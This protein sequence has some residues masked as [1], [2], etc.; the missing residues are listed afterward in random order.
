MSLFLKRQQEV[1]EARAS[2]ESSP[3]AR[4]LGTMPAKRQEN[5]GP[6]PTGGPMALRQL[7]AFLNSAL[8]V[9]LAA[10]SS[11]SGKT[12][13]KRVIKRD[14]LLPKYHEYVAQLTEGGRKHELVGRYLVW[15]IDALE[16]DQ[17]L[18]LAEWCIENGQTLPQNFK[19]TVQFFVADNVLTWA[20][21]E[22]AAGRSFAPY[23]QQTL[24][25]METGKWDVPDEIRAG[26]YSLFGKECMRLERWHEAEADLLKALKF[27]GKV[28][29]NLE[30]VQKQLA[31]I[32]K[33]EAE[34]KEK[35]KNLESAPAGSPSGPDASAGEP[36]EAQPGANS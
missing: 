36:K 28:K 13:A 17:A 25:L 5:P 29:T 30:T 21:S 3:G 32:A 2:G 12:E 8:E 35:N 23:L 18:K 24:D 26:Y 11:L 1:A 27:G 31:K 15:C 10:L 6:S 22:F 20:N 16:F 19:S 9:D 33:A 14:Q 7:D 34:Q 4:V